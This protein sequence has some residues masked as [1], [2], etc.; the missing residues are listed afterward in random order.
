VNMDPEETF[1]FSSSDNIEIPTFLSRMAERKWLREQIDLMLK[2][3]GVSRGVFKRTLPRMTARGYKYF[4]HAKGRKPSLRQ[5]YV[6]LKDLK[7]GIDKKKI[8]VKITEKE[9]EKNAQ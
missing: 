5:Q 2:D 8:E 4:I 6:F 1:S 9:E 3:I 7:V